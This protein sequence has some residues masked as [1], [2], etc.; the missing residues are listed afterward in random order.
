MYIFYQYVH[1]HQSPTKHV[2][3]GWTGDFFMAQLC[4]TPFLLVYQL[5]GVSAGVLTKIAMTSLW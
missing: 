2:R 1:I 3:I 4:R 5:F